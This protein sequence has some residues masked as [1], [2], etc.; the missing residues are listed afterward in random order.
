MFGISG[1]ELLVIILVAVLVIPAKHWGDVAKFVAGCIKFIRRIIWKITDASEQIREQIELEKPIDDLIKNTTDD[2]LAGFT[3]IR[4][5]SRNRAHTAIKKKQQ[6]KKA[7]VKK[8]S[9][10]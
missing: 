2:M 6:S 8:V 3:S 4:G 7:P 1:A 9:K 10:K 5:T